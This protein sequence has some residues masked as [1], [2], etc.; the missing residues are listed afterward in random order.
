MV[1]VVGMQGDVNGDCEADFL[2]FRL[3]ALH[4]CEN[5]SNLIRFSE[6]ASGRWG[7]ERQPT[8]L[9]FVRKFVQLNCNRTVHYLPIPQ[10]CLPHKC[11]SISK[12]QKKRELCIEFQR[13][14]CKNAPVEFADSAKK[15]RNEVSPP[16]TY[17]KW[18]K[19]ACADCIRRHL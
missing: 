7:C 16:R 6:R 12:L 18:K 8:S 15:K 9:F 3:M 10:K 4:W 17:S 1:T 2:D 14:S 19:N 5:N 13:P 11:C